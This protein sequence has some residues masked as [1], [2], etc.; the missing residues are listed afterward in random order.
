MKNWVCFTLF[1]CC[2]VLF[3]FI[4]SWN[5]R[6]VTYISFSVLCTCMPAATVI[7][8]TYTEKVKLKK[9]KLFYNFQTRKTQERVR[10]KAT[11]IAKRYIKRIPLLKWDDCTIPSLLLVVLLRLCTRD[12]SQFYCCGPLSVLLSMLCVYSIGHFIWFCAGYYL[13]LFFSFNFSFVYSNARAHEYVCV[14]VSSLVWWQVR[15]LLLP[16]F[17]MSVLFLFCTWISSFNVNFVCV[18]V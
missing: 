2:P 14:C 18:A 12:C 15:C 11:T 17:F 16:F 13:A 6:N 8:H 10:I 1:D 7:L 4:Y 3:F 9:N 5:E